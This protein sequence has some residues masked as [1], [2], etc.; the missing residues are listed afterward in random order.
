LY[1]CDTETVII[2]ETGKSYKERQ[3]QKT[4]KEEGYG[5]PGKK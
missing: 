1:L 4:K 3:D 5:K 2:E